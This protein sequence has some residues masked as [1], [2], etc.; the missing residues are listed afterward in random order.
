MFVVLAGFV[1]CQKEQTEEQ[2]NAEIERQVQQRLAAEHQASE[3]QQ[4]AQREGELNAREKSLADQKIMTVLPMLTT[5]LT[6]MASQFA[7]RMQP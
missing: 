4:L 1:S 2:K 7:R 5:S 3:Q 6:R